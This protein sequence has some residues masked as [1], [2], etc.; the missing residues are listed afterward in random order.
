M[1]DS[2]HQV[3]VDHSEA[4]SAL[5]DAVCRGG[6]FEVRMGHLATGDYLI[7]NEV[8]IERKSLSD[9]AACR[10]TGVCFHRYRFV[11]RWES[12]TPSDG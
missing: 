1:S 3:T 7:D 11:R 10:L 9:F 12:L 5:L 2:V 8:L 6:A 4:R